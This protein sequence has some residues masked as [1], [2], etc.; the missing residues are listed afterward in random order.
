LELSIAD[1]KLEFIALVWLGIIIDVRGGI[2][3][4]HFR[5]HHPILQEE[6]NEH[7]PRLCLSLPLFCIESLVRMNAVLGKDQGVFFHVL[8]DTMDHMYMLHSGLSDP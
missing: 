4:I 8:L 7:L 6:G 1:A 2:Q 5:V 3:T